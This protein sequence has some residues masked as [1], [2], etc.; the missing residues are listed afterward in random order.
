MSKL[1]FRHGDIL[2]VEVDAEMPKTTKKEGLMLAAG[3]QTN[4]GHFVTG[5]VEVLEAEDKNLFVEVG[6]K[7][8]LIRHL[9]ISEMKGNQEVWT[10]EHADIE[11]PAGKK[12]KVVRQVEYDPYEKK[13][14]EVKD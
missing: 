9:L 14:N 6:N 7:G 1:I 3:E 2:L 4:H 8:G 5:D 12:F 11:L 13:I 10:K